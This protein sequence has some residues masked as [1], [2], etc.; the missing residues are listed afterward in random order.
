MGDSRLSPSLGVKKEGITNVMLLSLELHYRDLWA[1]SLLLPFQG[2][3]PVGSVHL[4]ILHR[5]PPLVLEV[6][7]ESLENEGSGVL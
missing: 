4:Q 2:P 1:L 3:L 6:R 5:R 7:A